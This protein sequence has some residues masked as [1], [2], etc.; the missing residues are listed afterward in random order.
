MA[1]RIPWD[2]YETAILISACA[3]YNA[4]KCTKK[5]AIKDVSQTLRKR[6]EDNGIE[7]DDV[8][9]NENGITMQFM[10][11]NELMT[12]ERCGLRGASKMFINMVELYKTDRTK[13]QKILLEAKKT[14][15]VNKI[16]QEQFTAWL[17][18]QLSPAQMSEIYISY[19]DIDKYLQEEK[20]LEEPLLET[21]NLKKVESI[22]NM[23][24][25][26]GKFRFI[27]RS[28]IE[29]YAKAIGYYYTWLLEVCKK[30]DE[31]LRTFDEN[32][33]ETKRE[34]LR[35]EDSLI[36]HEH[37]EEAK[38]HEGIKFVKFGA[39]ETYPFTRVE[40]F[41]YFGK[42]YSDVG[43]WKKL[44][45]EVLQCLVAEYPN[46]INVLKG[47][48]LGSGTRIDIGNW[49]QSLLM[50]A[51]R[52]FE[53][54]LYVETNLNA[55]NILDKIKHLLDLCRIDA[56]N[57]V[58][59]YSLKDNEPKG[60]VSENIPKELVV[61]EPKMTEMD[62]G[63]VPAE[64]PELIENNEKPQAWN[65]RMFLEEHNLEYV[66]KTSKSGCLW[67][68][69]GREIQS[70]M[71]Q[72]WSHGVSFRFRESGGNVT[73]GKPAWW[74]KLSEEQFRNWGQIEENNDS[75]CVV[76]ENLG[77][78]NTS[79]NEEEQQLALILKDNYENGFRINSAIDRGRIKVFYDERFGKELP[80]SDEQLLVSLKK[81][82][83][84]REERIYAKQDNEQIYLLK[85]IYD[86]VISVFETGSTCVY[87]EAVYQKYH[88]ELEEMMQIY[89]AELLGNT[90]I[91]M[92]SGKLRKKQT[93]LCLTDRQADLDRDVLEV[94]KRSPVPMTYSDI[95]EVMWYIPLDKI[96]HILVV[97]KSIVQV[98]QE[99]YF[100]SMNLPISQEEITEV[101]RLI[102]QALE[103]RTY[104]T[105]VEL[106]KLIDENCPGVS[107]NT[108]EFTTYGLR[109]CLGYILRDSYSFNGPIISSLGKELSMAEVFAQY[110]DDR[111]QVTTEELKLFAS[112]MNT[113]IYWDSVRDETIRISDEVLL[114]YDKVDFE[115]DEIDGVLD[116]LC[117]KNYM[118]LKEIGLFMHFPALCVQWNG[119]VLESYVYKYSKKFKLLHASFSASGFFGAV[120]RQ[121][122]GIEDYRALIVDV[123]ANSEQWEDKNSA[124]ELLVEQG[125]QQRRKYADIEKVVHEAKLLREKIN[126][127][128]KR[129]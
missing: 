31:S 120:V 90:L 66:N 91:E 5:Q 46:E 68:I 12:Q 42:R 18:S 58:V 62:E 106:R 32:V 81:V 117:D 126:A 121:D 26:N 57:L 7:I 75:K 79:L 40:Y 30:T 8:F 50:T 2:E 63:E 94:I 44:Y 36:N 92:S 97:T 37:L 73:E 29:K 6:A 125:Y 45:V 127:T 33:N 22:R 95:Q 100:Y 116:T 103:H 93:F 110:C 84:V 109:N 11:V 89:E 83:V 38:E 98:E 20:I 49:E 113:V 65:L 86:D 105:D 128:R 54:N 10:L 53:T 1:I 85:Q 3:N 14:V 101:N 35:Q 74:T 70:L 28:K 60:E 118:P 43:S 55:T 41:E 56:E 21:T 72:C 4:G 52:M 96:K 87:P 112:E 59:A 111:E 107:I 48:S 78:E 13:F 124:L 99:T 122:S 123:L 47:K 16:D 104:I 114:R 39:G 108:S 67:V 88:I 102:H 19:Y 27:H 82:G 129:G 76:V 15:E 64:N 51:P 61:D 69:G 71:M 115:I 24:M 25:T 77:K 17:S 9:R 23:I 119:Y 34:I 80:M